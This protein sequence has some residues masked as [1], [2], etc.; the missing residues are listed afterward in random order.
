MASKVP[1]GLEEYNSGAMQFSLNRINDLAW[2]CNGLLKKTLQ[3]STQG[4]NNSESPY[5]SSRQL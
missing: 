4:R 1:G 2:L 5:A 3:W